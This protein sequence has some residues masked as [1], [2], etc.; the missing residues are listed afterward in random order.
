[1]HKGWIWYFESI[2]FTHTAARLAARKLETVTQVVCVPVVGL[3][4]TAIAKLKPLK[5][6]KSR[7]G[8]RIA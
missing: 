5:V 7:K 1:L 4:E 3:L 2:W 6:T 8:A